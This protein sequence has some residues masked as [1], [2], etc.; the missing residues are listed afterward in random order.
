[1]FNH[2]T[3]E[4]KAH[5]EQVYPNECCGFIVDGEY[6]PQQNIADNPTLDF[7]IMPQAYP[8]TG[9]QAVVHSHPKGNPSPSRLDMQGQILTDVP[10]GI[11]PM[12]DEIAGQPVWYGGNPPPVVGRPYR[13]GPSGSDGAGDCYAVIKDW[14]HIERGITLPEYP[15]QNGEAPFLDNFEDAGFTRITEKEME[16]GDVLLM[17]IHAKT[18]NHGG[19]YLGRG[20]WVHH[21]QLQLSRKDNLTRYKNF[22]THVLRYTP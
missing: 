6:R 22:L 12:S 5:A 10:W 14:Y 11:I 4:L 2:L 13:H 21:L 3:D 9:L 15:R 18:P 17:Q 7:E 8:L 19:V 1:M 16:P 20:Q